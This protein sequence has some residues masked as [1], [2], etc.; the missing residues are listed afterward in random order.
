M[1]RKTELVVVLFT[2]VAVFVLMGLRVHQVRKQQRV[3][4]Q[5][6]VETTTST[7]S[8]NNVSPTD[9]GVI[10]RDKGAS[11]N[12]SAASSNQPQPVVPEQK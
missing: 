4:E 3:L 9:G 10:V 5:Q 6:T 11:I 8:N 7:P 1:N 12:F 2:V